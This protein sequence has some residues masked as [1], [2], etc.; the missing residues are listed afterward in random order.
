MALALLAPLCASGAG[1]TPPAAPPSPGAVSTTTPG[2]GPGATVAA[3]SLPGVPTGHVTSRGA[4][5]A[6]NVPAYTWN[7][8][9]EVDTGL[10]YA[11]EF[12]ITAV[13][14]PAPH[15]C[16][17]LDNSGTLLS[18][19][20]PTATPPTW[21]RGGTTLPGG[22]RLLRC[23]ST[24]LCVAAGAEGSGAL[25]TSTSPTATSPS[26]NT[27]TV[28]EGRTLTAIAC[29]AE[30]LCLA[31]DGTGDVLASDHP[32]GGA[33]TWRRVTVG[34]PLTALTCPSTDF[35][36]AAN[37]EGDMYVSPTPS[38]PDTWSSVAP[39]PLSVA[40]VSCVSSELCVAVGNRGDGHFG[41]ARAVATTTDPWAEI[42][43]GRWNA[44][45]LS[46]AAMHDGVACFPT[47]TCLL[48]GY[49]A[50]AAGDTDRPVGTAAESKAAESTTPSSLWVRGPDLG[51]DRTGDSAC[52]SPRLC[53]VTT[54]TGGLLTSTDPMGGPGAWRNTTGVHPFTPFTAVSCGTGICAAVDST[55]H[56]ATSTDPSSGSWRPAPINGG[57]QLTAVDCVSRALCVAADA[58]GNVL[59]ST[60]PSTGPWVTRRL[61][62]G[63]TISAVACANTRLCVAVTAD[64][65]IYSTREPAGH[66]TRRAS[67]RGLGPRAL[68]CPGT[69]LCVVAGTQ[70]VVTSA[71]PL[72]R[73]WSTFR[74]R[75]TVPTDA[76]TDVT[77]P[78]TSFCVLAVENATANRVL[79][80]RRP[81]GG[82]SAWTVT[83]PG[84]RLGRV[85]CAT[86]N[87]C[88]GIA[89]WGATPSRRPD[90]SIV[91]TST[92]AVGGS[93]RAFP[94]ALPTSWPG[95]LSC[96]PGG[97]CVAVNGNRM[98]SARS[99]A[100]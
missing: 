42:G 38:I 73:A 45:A 11:G 98:I 51:E 37:P 93:W 80:S 47:G 56:V 53:L 82:S 16:L 83:E 2:T 19:A 35:C 26:W 57:H 17:A 90:R 31:L 94:V 21:T 88:F 13:S 69:T 60:S 12:E 50:L 75:P 8:S 61:R 100:R 86:P 85:S 40:G 24:S 36:L 67:V 68:D 48:T 84:R 1:A 5:R 78:T 25:H 10:P 99:D 34:E 18:S 59:S 58:R 3:R 15:V 72:T 89:P 52:P 43:R 65:E 20:D 62:R 71:A 92:P 79:V 39:P 22:A 41:Y 9:V 70:R 87:A 44:T 66:W 46:D 33:D 76:S 14:C 81:R 28:S 55:G 97:T 49:G 54:S 64:G 91:G 7:T 77:C 74:L 27:G 30:N 6:R 4:T 32:A 23:P 29:P 96:A 95:A 63:V